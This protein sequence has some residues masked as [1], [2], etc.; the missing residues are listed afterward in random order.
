[1]GETGV[2]SVGGAIDGQQAT[3]TAI[4]TATPAR[5]RAIRRGRTDPASA[6]ADVEIV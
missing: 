1:V 3:A 5:R 4:A 2:I 6:S